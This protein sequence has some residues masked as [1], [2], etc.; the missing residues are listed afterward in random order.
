MAYILFSLY[1]VRRIALLSDTSIA[2]L[3]IVF[4]VKSEFNTYMSQNII[5]KH[6]FIGLAK[7]VISAEV[8]AIEVLYQRLDEDFVKTF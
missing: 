3:A 2:F 6:D 1:C 8:E 5:E 4:K 7:A